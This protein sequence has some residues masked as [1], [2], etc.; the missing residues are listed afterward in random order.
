MVTA[1]L[2]FLILPLSIPETFGLSF[3]FSVFSTGASDAEDVG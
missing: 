2:R 1:C 3:D